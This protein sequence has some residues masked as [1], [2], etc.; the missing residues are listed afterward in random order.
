M[1]RLILVFLLSAGCALGSLIRWDAHA[2]ATRSDL[3]SVP[4]STV[5]QVLSSGFRTLAAD[6]LYLR[7]TSYWG[8]QLTHGR[9]FHNL[10][11]ILER[12]VDLDPR[13]RPAYELGALALGD[14]GQPLEAVKL[15][16]RGGA[17]DPTSW[18][19]PYQAGMTLFFFSEDYLHAA[20]YFEKAGRMPGAPDSAAFLAARMYEKGA[21]AELARSSWQAILERTSDPNV[22]EVAR[23]AL[24]RLKNTP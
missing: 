23:H 21:H 14:A 11:P 1:A 22:R 9:R 16:E 3:L 4:P 2:G 19:Y 6:L 17:H 18:W 24:E 5:T 20:A 13:F 10:V 15:L 7:F 8:H 12:I